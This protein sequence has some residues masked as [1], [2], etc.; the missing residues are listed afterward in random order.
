MQKSLRDNLPEF[1]D[2]SKIPMADFGEVNL[3]EGDNN[4]YIIL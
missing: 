4:L 2:V 1:R 3:V